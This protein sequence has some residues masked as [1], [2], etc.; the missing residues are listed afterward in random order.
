MSFM[1]HQRITLIALRVSSA[2]MYGLFVQRSRNKQLCQNTNNE[3]T[4]TIRSPYTKYRTIT[5]FVQ[6]E[7]KNLFVVDMLFH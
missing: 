2:V 5:T 1:Y 4:A 3:N 6:W 7:N